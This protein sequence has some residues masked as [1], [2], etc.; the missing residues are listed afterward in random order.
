MLTS[1]PLQAG[2]PY[3]FTNLGEVNNK[4]IEVSMGW[5][6][7]IGKDLTFNLSGNFSYNK[8][9]VLS[10]GNNIDFQITGNGGVNLTNTGQSIGYFYGYRQTGIYQSTADLDKTPKFNNSLP[11]DI[12][13]EDVNGDGVITADDRTNI[14]SPFPDF[15]Y[16]MTNTFAYKGFDFAFTLQGVQGF[17]VLN[18]ARRF[19]GN[20]AGSYNVLKSTA[21]GWKSE[22]DRGDGVSPQ[23]DRNFNALG[24]ASVI[25]N[26]TS[27]FVED[28][29]FLRIR[30]I[31]LG[32]NLPASIAKSLK[33]ANARLSFT[34]QNAYTFTNYEGYNPEVSVEGANPLMPG[35]DSGG[36]P[37]AR[38][39]MFGLNFGF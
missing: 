5:T 9:Q 22:S 14:G 26:A 25:N 3:F 10:I 36:Y 33:V 2:S 6:D 18:A 12:S 16:G 37:L 4:G 15:T 28:G 30:N 19:Y 11:G 1:F 32:Y 39:Y 17:E 23:I 27:A 8:N 13:Y 7:K 31:T 29:S 35:V 38:T 20:Y 24:N 21:N 34:V